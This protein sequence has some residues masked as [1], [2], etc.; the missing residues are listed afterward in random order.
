MRL[1]CHSQRADVLRGRWSTVK[2]QEFLVDWPP[3]R[4]VADDPNA[5]G[6]PENPGE[7]RLLWFTSPDE[8]GWFSLTATDPE[9][10]PWS[11]FY[12]TQ[13]QD[14]WGSL[15]NVLASNLGAPLSII[16]TVDLRHQ[17]RRTR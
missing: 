2:V 17:P 5:G 7:L 8:D 6:S 15:E 9:G 10:R 11:T 14:T 4:W 3:D 12:R 13:S 16:G 1:D